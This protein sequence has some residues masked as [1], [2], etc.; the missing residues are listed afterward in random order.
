MHWNIG[1]SILAGIVGGGSGAGFGFVLF[2][3]S[4]LAWLLKNASSRWLLSQSG[5]DEL[6]SRY[7]ATLVVGV[8]LGTGAVA[9]KNSIPRQTPLNRAPNVDW[10][11]R[12]LIDVL[13]AQIVGA[14]WAATGILG[15]D[16]IRE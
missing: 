4:F 2:N 13:I 11:K 10:S 3:W 12:F 15:P 5:W 16:E 6:I 1:R 8:I 14:A 7:L 9:L